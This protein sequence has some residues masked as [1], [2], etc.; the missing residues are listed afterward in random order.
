VNL[1]IPPDKTVYH[2]IQNQSIYHNIKQGDNVKVVV[3]NGCLSNMWIIGGF[4]LKDND[5]LYRQINI[6]DIYPIG[7]VYISVSNS[8]P[9]SLF[10]GIWEEINDCF[11]LASGSKH[12]AGETG[13]S[14]TY[15][16]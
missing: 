11:L 1:T 6:D 14:E 4:S 13:G 2:N 5:K 12:T 16:L 9:S 10:G 7:S 8:N 15:A 3:E